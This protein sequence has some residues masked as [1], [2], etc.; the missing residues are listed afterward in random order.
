MDLGLAFQKLKAMQGEEA[1]RKEMI[2]EFTKA[3]QS[4]GFSYFMAENLA[5]E[6]YNQI[7]KQP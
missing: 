5:K 3:F 6:K 4:Q 2:A 1:R 7:H